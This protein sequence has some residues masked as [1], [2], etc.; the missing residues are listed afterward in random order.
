MALR[1]LLAVEMLIACLRVGYAGG[2]GRGGAMGPQ[3]FPASY[4]PAAQAARKQHLLMLAFY[5][6]RR[7]L[8]A[9]TVSACSFYRYAVP[10]RLQWGV[11]QVLLLHVWAAAA[12]GTGRQASSSALL[13]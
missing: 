6:E 5:T 12:R 9:A 10:K 1:R 7:L 8:H 3:V 2:M 11:S 13:L 4:A